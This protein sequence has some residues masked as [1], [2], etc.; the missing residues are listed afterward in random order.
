[1]CAI[2]ATL[3]FTQELEGLLTHDM[4]YMGFKWPVFISRPLDLIGM[5]SMRIK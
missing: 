2:R 3:E 1:M 5:C 4:M